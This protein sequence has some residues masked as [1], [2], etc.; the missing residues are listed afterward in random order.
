MEFTI[1]TAAE[2]KT[3]KLTIREFLPYAHVHMYV[4]IYIINV[5]MHIWYMCMCNVYVSM[6]IVNGFALMYVLVH[7]CVVNASIHAYMYENTHKLFLKFKYFWNS[8]FYKCN[9]KALRN[10]ENYYYN[11]VII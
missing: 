1:P 3:K 4:Y 6:C 10:S 11:C 2:D 8:K 7:T 9:E 5:Y